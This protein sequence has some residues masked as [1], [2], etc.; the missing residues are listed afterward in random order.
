MAEGRTYWVRAEKEGKASLR[1]V[2]VDED[3][4]WEDFGLG[5]PVGMPEHPVC[6]PCPMRPSCEDSVWTDGL[7]DGGPV[8]PAAH[9][10]Q[11]SHCLTC[12]R[13]FFLHL[14]LDHVDV[15]CPRARHSPQSFSDCHEC[16]RRKASFP[17][18]VGRGCAPFPEGLEEDVAVRLSP[19]MDGI[20]RM[21]RDLLRK[22]WAA[23]IVGAGNPHDALLEFLADL[24]SR[25]RLG[26]VWMCLSPAER[27]LARRVWGGII[28]RGLAD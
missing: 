15:A 13:A 10:S 18:V 7:R 3:F 26:D 12:G 28:R 19:A 8:L 2:T 20:G 5:R 24:T 11:A 6:G 16:L 21:K 25:D 17:S 27:E 14:G 23:R 22:A 9:A 4:R 1:A